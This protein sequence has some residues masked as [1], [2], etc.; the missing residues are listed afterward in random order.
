MSATFRRGSG[1][2]GSRECKCR[3]WSLLRLFFAK[4]SEASRASRLQRYVGPS[5]AHLSVVLISLCLPFHS[6]LHPLRFFG[7]GKKK[8]LV[9]VDEAVSTTLQ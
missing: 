9:V 2:I 5:T 4:W 8:N 6:Q 3:F 7:R 1:I